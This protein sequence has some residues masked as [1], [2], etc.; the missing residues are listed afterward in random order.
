LI[1]GKLFALGTKEL[2]VQFAARGAQ[3][4]IQIRVKAKAKKSR[5]TVK[6]G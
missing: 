5:V 2:E 1:G 6:K 3:L 4:F